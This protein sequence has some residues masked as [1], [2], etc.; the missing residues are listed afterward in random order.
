MRVGGIARKTVDTFDT[1]E[2][3]IAY[4]AVM[5][6]IL[7][8]EEPYP[9]VT[10]AE[11]GEE[12][13]TW[14]ELSRH[15]SRP[16]NDWSR[17]KNHMKSDPIAKMPVKAVREIHIEDW[18][19]RLNA[20]GLARQT[21]LHCLNLMRIIFRRA[22]KKRL[23]K[24]NPCLDVRLE[25]EKRTHDPWT[26]LTPE[27]QDAVIAATPK[28]LDAIVEF[29]IGT[30]LRSGEMAALRLADVHLDGDDPYVTVRYGGP[31]PGGG[32]SRGAQLSRSRKAMG[33]DRLARGEAAGEGRSCPRCLAHDDQARRRARPPGRHRQHRARHHRAQARRERIAPGE[34]LARA[35]VRRWASWGAVLAGSDEA[36]NRLR[37]WRK[38]GQRSV[39]AG[40]PEDRASV[41]R[42][43]HCVLRPGPSAPGGG[44]LGRPSVRLPSFFAAGRMPSSCGCRT[45][46]LPFPLTS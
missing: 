32:A 11:F 4:R 23:A 31:R 9:G 45:G 39:R 22:K 34:C 18:M 21:R 1:R 33:R 36:S 42:Q 13:L 43:C 26:F 7:K 20:K 24:E 29:A 6:D 19:D 2:E 25:V 10:I 38:R 8:N 44:Q 40:E 14:R 17:W 12:V 16:E 35:R 28:P 46:G 37:D 15:L 30:G 5:S 3:A 41:R 27:E